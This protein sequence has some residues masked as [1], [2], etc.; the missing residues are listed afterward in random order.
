M[1]SHPNK[2][3][4]NMPDLSKRKAAKIIGIGAGVFWVVLGLILSLLAGEKFGGVLGGMLIGIFILVS[5]LIAYRSE[6]VG[7]MLLLLEGLISAGFILMSFFSGKALWWVA[8]ILFLILSLPPLISGYLFTQC[9][10]EFK[11]QTDI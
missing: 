10:K 6:L 9:W 7:G 8:L 3:Q 11:Q 5:T 2:R 1:D 4:N